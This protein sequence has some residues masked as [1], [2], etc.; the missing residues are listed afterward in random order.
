MRSARDNP[1]LPT[2]SRAS[3]DPRLDEWERQAL[4]AL[5]DDD[6]ETPCEEKPTR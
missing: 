3:L 6:D 2:P 5:D 4:E 1:Q